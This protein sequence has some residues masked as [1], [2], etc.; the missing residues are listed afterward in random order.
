MKVFVV[1]LGHNA[2]MPSPDKRCASIIIY[3]GHSKRT[4][5]QVDLMIQQLDRIKYT[6]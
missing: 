1:K 6:M 2:L 5:T 4:V 3:V